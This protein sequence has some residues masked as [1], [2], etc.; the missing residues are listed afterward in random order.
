M[1]IKQVNL[2][3]KIYL[4]RAAKNH[5]LWLWILIDSTSLS[6]GNLQFKLWEMEIPL[7]EIWHFV[8][9]RLAYIIREKSFLD[10]NQFRILHINCGAILLAYTERDEVACSHLCSMYDGAKWKPFSSP[11][12]SVLFVFFHSQNLACQNGFFKHRFQTMH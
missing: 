6:F 12:S 9:I 2:I 4:L 3:Q 11:I 10:A 7:V 1:N 8:W 5:I